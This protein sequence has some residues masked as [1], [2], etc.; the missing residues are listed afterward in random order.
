MTYHED[1]NASTS[2]GLHDGGYFISRGV[3][4]TNKADQ[5]QPRL[6]MLHDLSFKLGGIR[7][8]QNL[9]LAHCL[10]SQQDDSLSL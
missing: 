9:R 6:S 2:E 1:T 10:A 3:H 8:G 4:D 5:S 7:A